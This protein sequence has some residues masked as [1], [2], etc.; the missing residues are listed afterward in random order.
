M[1][2]ESNLFLSYFGGFITILEGGIETG[3]HHV[4][5]IEYKSKLFQIKGKKNCRVYEVPC[6]YES[7]NI[8][9]TFILGIIHILIK[10]DAG[11]KIYLWV[12][13]KTNKFESYKGMSVCQAIKDQRTGS[14]LIKLDQKGK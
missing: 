7:L 6:T 12:P 11:L 5:S 3:F 13:T 4:G 14:N 1:G 2:Y 9:D 8:G 10:I